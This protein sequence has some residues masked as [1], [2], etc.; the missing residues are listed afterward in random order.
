MGMHPITSFV[1]VSITHEDLFVLSD[2][3][4]GSPGAPDPIICNAQKNDP[5]S[6]LF[7]A[8][9]V[10]LLIIDLLKRRLSTFMY[11]NISFTFCMVPVE[12]ICT[13]RNVKR[14][15]Q[16]QTY[17]ICQ[18]SALT[19]TLPENDVI[20]LLIFSRIRVGLY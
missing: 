14:T 8:K 20:K 19:Y 18:Y 10:A 9:F 17:P 5:L 1:I 12:A 2:I 7:C 6:S 15:C 16:K 4:A 11:C 13:Y 3:A